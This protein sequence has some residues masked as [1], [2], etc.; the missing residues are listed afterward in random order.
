MGRSANR[1][2]MRNVAVREGVQAHNAVSRRFAVPESRKSTSMC[3][4]CPCN[5]YILH[6]ASCITCK[7]S[8]SSGCRASNCEGSAPLSRAMTSRRAAMLLET[9][10]LTESGSPGCRYFKIW[11]SHIFKAGANQLSGSN[12]F[13]NLAMA[14]PRWEMAFLASGPI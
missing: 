3:P 14:R 2:L 11:V 9:G 7:S 13:I 5:P 1:R 8:H 4:L 10:T 6:T 12:T